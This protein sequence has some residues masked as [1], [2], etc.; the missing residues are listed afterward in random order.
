[1][2][3]QE[4]DTMQFLVDAMMG[5]LSSPTRIEIICRALGLAITTRNE[6]AS[7]S[8]FALL[9]KELGLGGVWDERI[10]KLDE[11][12]TQQQP[13]RD[14]LC[15]T[16]MAVYPKGSI[17]EQTSNSKPVFLGIRK[18]MLEFVIGEWTGRSTELQFEIFEFIREAL[19]PGMDD[20]E[21]LTAETNMVQSLIR[22]H[23]EEHPFD[24]PTLREW[25]TD[26]DKSNSIAKHKW[27]DEFLMLLQLARVRSGGV[28]AVRLDLQLWNA[29]NGRP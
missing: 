2:R 27:N 4:V 29:A 23:L 19:A 1:M 18:E 5:I 20:V 3:P 9:Y 10:I 15:R 13:A 28:A 12:K 24:E 17:Q 26:L 16:V 8:L 14:E 25:M 21:L 7:R 6:P 11:F 22:T